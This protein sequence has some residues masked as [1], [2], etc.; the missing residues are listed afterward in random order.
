VIWHGPIAAFR[1]PEGFWSRSQYWAPEVH[2]HRGRF[3]L[4]ATFL[5]A[6]SGVRGV[7]VLAAD[8]PIGPYTPWSDGPVT[9][10]GVPCLD[11]TLVF[12][13]GAPW[14]VYSRGPEAVPG[15]SSVSIGEMHALRLSEDLRAADGEPTVLFRACDANW[16]TPLPVPE[17][18]RAALGLANDPLLTDGPF[19]RCE[20]DGSL[21]MLWSSHGAEGYAMGIATAPSVLGPWS[22]RDE[23]LW[24][25]NGG[26]GMILRATTGIDLL[27]FHHPN[28]SPDERTKLVPLA[29]AGSATRIL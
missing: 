23:P 6:E 2:E 21:V 27:V 1:P 18:M 20:E 4:I 9:P 25:S 10:R 16:T 15:S 17:D 22:Q 12:E 13:D 3:Y 26:H 24:T 29:V 14:L 19:L 28:D 7:G 5:E 11:G 8:A